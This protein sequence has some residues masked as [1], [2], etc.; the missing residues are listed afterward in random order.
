[1]YIDKNVRDGSS[2][3]VSGTVWR[4]SCTVETTHHDNPHIPMTISVT[5][6]MYCIML[7][8]IGFVDINLYRQKRVRMT[9]RV[10]SSVQVSGTANTTWLT[11]ID[12]AVRMAHDIRINIKDHYVL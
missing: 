10:Y 6:I 11:I 5:I 4:R 3:L 9:L 8:F 7:M 1:M 2:H 12:R